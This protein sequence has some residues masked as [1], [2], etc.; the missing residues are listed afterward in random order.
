VPHAVT[1]IMASER[2]ASI[3]FMVRF[4]CRSMVQQRQVPAVA[5][6]KNTQIAWVF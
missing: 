2:A 3:R 1:V 4:L 6:R 5:Y